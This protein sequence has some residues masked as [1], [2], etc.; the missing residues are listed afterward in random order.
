L[1]LFSKKE[2]LSS[3][4]EGFTS[5]KPLGRKLRLFTGSENNLMQ[6]TLR[7]EAPPP[8]PA[9]RGDSAESAGV[10]RRLR[11]ELRQAAHAHAFELMYQPRITLADGTLCGMQPHLRWPRR[12]GG[13]SPASAFMPLLAECGLAEGVA[14]WAFTQ[15]C[16]Q[17]APWANVPL[18]VAVSGPSLHD[19][20]LLAQ[21][22]AAL[23][24][25]G[26]PPDRLEIAFAEP[27][28]MADTMEALLAIAAL[29]DL[30]VGVALDEFG[31]AS[32]N[33]MTLKR[34]PL[35]ALKLD[36]TL[37]RDLPQ[38]REAAAVVLAAIDFAHALE[39]TVVACGV[40]T[41]QQRDFLLRAGCDQAQGGLCGKMVSAE[42]A[43]AI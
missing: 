15:A 27:T 22:G 32:A 24:E 6:E 41:R 4:A 37:V 19:G 2:L 18:C 26:L 20:S 34:L 28:L 39:V 11:Q 10:W 13:T 31:C 36:R 35:T 3:L 14:D 30:G 25:T 1:V 5:R 16:R 12:R 33:L 21:I 40:E 29:R 9:L 17:A 23:A 43:G 42:A 7:H 8:A 38:D